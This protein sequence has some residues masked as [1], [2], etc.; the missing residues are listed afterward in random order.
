MPDCP[1]CLTSID[2]EHGLRIHHSKIHNE[3]LP[4]RECVVCGIEFYSQGGQRCSEHSN[5]KGVANPNWKDAKKSATCVVCDKIFNYYPSNKEGKYCSECV[6]DSE[7][8]W[9]IENLKHGNG[10]KH[11]NWKGGGNKLTCEQCKQEFLTYRKGA[12]FCSRNCMGEWKSENIRGRN[13]HNYT[14]YDGYYGK[15]WWSQRKK[16]RMIDDATCQI[17]GVTKN[18]I[19]RYPDV[20]HIIPKN[21]FDDLKKANRI[22][23]LISLCPSCHHNVEHG[24]IQLPDD[25]RI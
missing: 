7:I 19:D 17:C 18:D 6:E 20:H 22:N 16:R 15:N 4:N 3:R 1:T 23:N 5:M 25:R 2:T 14:G 13:H 9:G 24:N 8:N 12:R 11:A 10:N 21:E